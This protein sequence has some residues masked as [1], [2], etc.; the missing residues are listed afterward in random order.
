MARL[1]A[2]RECCRQTIKAG[3]AGRQTEPQQAFGPVE[4]SAPDVLP[5]QCAVQLQC[6]GT[7]CEAKQR[8]AAD[9][10]KSALHKNL[11]KFAR[12]LGKYAARPIGPWLVA[13]RSRADVQRRAGARPRAE[14]SGDAP[15]QIR[16]AD[17]KTEAQPGK[18]IEFAERAQ[19]HHRQIGAHRHRADV[20]ID[21]GEGLIKH[22]PATAVFQS[23][24]GTHQRDMTRDASIGIVGVD[25]DDMNGAFGHFAEI[26]NRDDFAPGLRPG[27]RVLAKGRPNDSNL[28]RC[29]EI[30]QPLDQ[31][32]C[33][34]SGS[35]VSAIRHAIGFSSGGHQ[36][37]LI[38]ARRQALPYVNRQTRGD[39]PRTRVDSGREVKPIVRRTAM[40]R[41]C[42]GQV[43]TMLHTRFMPSS[44][45]KREGVRGAFTSIGMMA[46]VMMICAGLP[47]S[48]HAADLPRV[49]S[50]NLCTDQLLMTLANPEQ[51]LGLSPYSRD[52]ARSWDAAKARKFPRLSGEAEDVLVLNPD[53]VVAGRFT[54]RATR[55][56]LKEKGLRV[57]E[58]DAARSLDDVKKQIWQMGGLVQHPDRAATEVQRLDTAIARARAVVSRRPYRV[59]ALSR[60]GWVS[61]GD[62][63]TSS[64]LA[65]AGLSNA[66]ADLGYKLGGFASLEAIVSLRPDFL[67]VSDGGDFAEDEGRAFVLH[68]ALERFYPASKRLV[69]PEKLTVC[70]GSMLSEALDRLTSEL[71]RVAH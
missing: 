51:I 9:D 8:R 45:S 47:G 36:G 4:A 49:A 29:C 54:K 3:V 65:T 7:P 32:L 22:Q 19:D 21:I 58:F 28:P 56:L 39:R 5:R 2:Q 1:M 35:D 15:D 46:W 48:S 38:G 64:L 17:R 26:G 60:R 62:S 23:R 66:A 43:T 13:Q 68:P 61:G 33:S 55:E 6:I 27:D 52:A 40:A 11:I 18:A 14:C 59:L 16:R 67:L 63:L 41:D 30:R 12:L 34:G 31:H 70:G 37:I 69:I 53:I 57:V 25:D 10:R 44:A 50:I 42:F 71:E 20:R 24:S